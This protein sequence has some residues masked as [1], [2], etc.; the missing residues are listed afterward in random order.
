[1]G[2]HFQIL[3]KIDWTT[4]YFE[5][6]IW[7]ILKFS[8]CYWPTDLKQKNKPQLLILVYIITMLTQ[9]F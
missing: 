9:F 4:E 8:N 7:E 2:Y 3:Q 6:V 1:M 5:E